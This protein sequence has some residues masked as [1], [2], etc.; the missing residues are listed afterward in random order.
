MMAA[1]AGP[2][3]LGSLWQG[4]T[5]QGAIA[6]FIT[7][8]VVFL[9]THSGAIDP[10]WFTQAGALRAAAD[11]LAYQAPSPYSCA[12]MGEIASVFVTVLVSLS[13]ESVAGSQLETTRGAEA[14]N[15]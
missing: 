12:A 2:L 5:A 15:T 4:V 3:V 7:G 14:E 13:T 6:G 1:L 9:I 11:W 8:A 10:Q